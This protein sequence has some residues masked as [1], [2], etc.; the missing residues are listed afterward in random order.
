MKRIKFVFF[1]KK[2]HYYWA[3]FR[4]TKYTVMMT[5]EGSTKIVKFCIMYFSDER[6][7]ETS[8]SI[9]NNLKFKAFPELATPVSTFHDFTKKTLKSSKKNHVG[10]VICFSICY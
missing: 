3:W 5:N 10:C 7:N 2:F 4:Q 1:L 8:Q 9:H 6:I